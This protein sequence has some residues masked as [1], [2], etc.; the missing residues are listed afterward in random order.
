MRITHVIKKSL[1]KVSL[2]GTSALLVVSL[3]SP[4]MA[5]AVPSTASTS[6]TVI[7]IAGGYGT[8]ELTGQEFGSKFCTGNYHC[9]D[10]TYANYGYSSENQDAANSLDTV[11]H[12]TTGPV[13]V[14]GQS[15]GALV[16]DAWLR[17]HDHDANAPSPSQVS[18]LLT[19]NTEREYTGY[20]TVNK[21]LNGFVCTASG[22]GLPADTPYNVTDF[23]SQWDGWC[24]W[25]T[26]Y[27]SSYGQTWVHDYYST[28]NYDNPANI[29]WQEGKVTY[30]NSPTASLDYSWWPDTVNTAHPY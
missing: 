2:F 12:K 29:S 30:V 16:I 24:D 20:Q 26:D 5:A 9:Q 21:N 23:C 25:T 6:T 1:K 17:D 8:P 13:L 27:R 7:L 3:A 10:F 14:F 28:V 22:C 18:F 15:E 11:L 4:A 19:G